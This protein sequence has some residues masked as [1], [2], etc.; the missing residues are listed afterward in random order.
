MKGSSASVSR[1]ALA[2]CLSCLGLPAATG[3]VYAQETAL[4]AGERAQFFDVD[5]PA[6]PL[7]DALARFAVISGRSALF[8]ASLVSGRMSSQVSGRY[9][10]K[11]A[12]HRLLEGTGLDVEEISGGRVAALVLKPVAADGPV[13]GTGVDASDLGGYEALVQARIWDAICAYPET[14]LASYRA[15]IRFRVAPDGH[16]YHLRLLGST[17]DRAR[18]VVL[19]RALAPVRM[20]RAPPPKMSQPVT[21]A[22]LPAQSGGPACVAAGH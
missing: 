15:L 20:D 13:A 21:M 2:G 14:S 4:A 10:A 6:Q 5:I 22:I 12:L 18:D 17:G 19:M 3:T 1:L 7:V 11:A 8:P 16:V 9:T